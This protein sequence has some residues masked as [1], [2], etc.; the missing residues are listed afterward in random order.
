MGY[1]DKEI[2]CRDCGT[3]FIWTAGEQSF[4]ARVGYVQPR[5]CQACRIEL[6]RNIRRAEERLARGEDPNG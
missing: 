1:E 3:P 5:R 2:K 4:F 6:K